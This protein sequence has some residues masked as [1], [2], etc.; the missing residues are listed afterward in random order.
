MSLYAKAYHAIPA[1]FVGTRYLSVTC[2]AVMLG[3]A[4]VVTR[5]D[6]SMMLF[7]P[8][9][10]LMWTAPILGWPETSFSLSDDLPT[11]SFDHGVRVGSIDV[12]QAVTVLEED[13]SG[14]LRAHT[15]LGERHDV[16]I[17]LV[18]RYPAARGAG[19]EEVARVG[20]GQ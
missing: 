14:E 20:Q 2:K 6:Q 18:R 7:P 1:H 13:G 9:H 16:E 17:V 3:P 4:G 11:Y 8:G 5:G 15:R 19:R 12:G 10:F